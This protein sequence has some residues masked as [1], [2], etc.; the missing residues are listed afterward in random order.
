MTVRIEGQQ[1]SDRY[2]I[3]IDF[4]TRH[5]ISGNEVIKVFKAVS[6]LL[7]EGK[8]PTDKNILKKMEKL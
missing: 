2:T 4:I 8:K 5:G 3:S 7:H 1:R 6:N